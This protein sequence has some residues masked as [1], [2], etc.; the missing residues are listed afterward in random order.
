[1]TVSE[2]DA[3]EGAAEASLGTLPSVEEA[4][5]SAEGFDGA[6]SGRGVTGG[7]DEALSDGEAAGGVLVAAGTVDVAAAASGEAVVADEVAAEELPGGVVVPTEPI[8][9]S[10]GAT[11]ASQSPG[12]VFSMPFS[13]YTQ[14]GWSVA[15][16]YIVNPDFETSALF[17]TARFETVIFSTNTSPKWTMSF[18]TV[19][20][21]ACRVA[22][23]ETEEKGEVDE[24]EGASWSIRAVS[25]ARAPVVEACA[26]ERA[27]IPT[28]ATPAGSITEIVVEELFSPKAA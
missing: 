27:W 17:F 26:S 24:A 13:K 7:V 21:N 16:S 12:E 28:K 3:E 19:A 25:P 2:V 4:A 18:M 20:P 5:G 22:A 10:A 9:G 14:I 23:S 6:E 15:R 8:E 1:M 11:G